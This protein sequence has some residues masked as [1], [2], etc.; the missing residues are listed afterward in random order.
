VAETTAVDRGG[1]PGAGGPS[2]YAG[3]LALA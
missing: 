1:H 2:G 3:T